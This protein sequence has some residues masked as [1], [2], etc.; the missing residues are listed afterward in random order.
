LSADVKIIISSGF[1]LSNARNTGVK[2]TQGEVA[3]FVDDDAL[4]D[5]DW[6]KNL[7]ANYR[8]SNVVGVGGRIVPV[9]EG[10]FPVW[11]PAELN[12]IVGC[13][14]KGLPEEKASVRNPIGCNMSFRRSVF[15]AVGYFRTD[16]G[17][18]GRML[19]AGEE[20]EFSL[21]ILTMLPRSKIIYDP[22]AVVYHKVAKSRRSLAYIL[23][24]SFYEGISKALIDSDEANIRKRSSTENQYLKYLTGVTV[25]S[26]AKR[27]YRFENLSHLMVIFLSTSAVLLGFFFGKISR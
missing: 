12:W 11:F 20:P 6:L 15:D 21:R 22:S 5:V 3:A 17:R 8:E 25:P 13:S 18:I 19:L 14:Y 23:K 16:V 9:W 1:G 24:R 26:K 7:A 10:G 27:I 4:A 2:S